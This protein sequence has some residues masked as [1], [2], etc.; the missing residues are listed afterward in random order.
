MIS[1]TTKRLVQEFW[2]SAEVSRQMPLKKKVKRNQAAFCLEMNYTQAFQKFKAAHPTVKIGYVRFIQLKPQNVRRMGAYERIVCCCQKCEKVKLKLKALN[3]VVSSK[4]CRDLCID[5]E[6]LTAISDITLCHDDDRILPKVDCL[7]RKCNS[8]GEQNV[9]AHY[10]TFLRDNRELRLK[11]DNW[12]RVKKT[13]TV[14]GA[15]KEF[16]VTKLLTE[17]TSTLATT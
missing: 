2:W 13:K 12:T 4:G 3:C 11:Y 9:S 14:K 10:E 1:D 15:D 7:D 8:C 6:N 17:E 16:T 5:A